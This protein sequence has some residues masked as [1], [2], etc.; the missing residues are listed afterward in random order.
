MLVLEVLDGRVRDAGIRQRR[1]DPE[2]DGR[3]LDELI[4]Q[5]RR[6]PEDAERRGPCA[7]VVDAAFD[8]RV[9]SPFAQR[10]VRLASVL[11]ADHRDVDACSVAERRDAIGD[12]PVPHVPE[13][14]RVGTC[15]STP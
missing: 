7:H 5:I 3:T 4:E 14:E 6:S 8:D 1:I 15:L 2:S 12:R 11:E 10:G 9:D 13:L